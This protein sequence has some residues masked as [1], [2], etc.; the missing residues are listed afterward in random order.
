MTFQQILINWKTSSAGFLLIISGIVSIIYAVN[1]TG[2][3]PDQ[4]ILMAQLT[5]IFGGLGL[6]LSRDVNV[7]TEA[8]NGHKELEDAGERAPAE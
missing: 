3:A 1:E 2:R 5:A 6:L 7:S 8:T 4:S